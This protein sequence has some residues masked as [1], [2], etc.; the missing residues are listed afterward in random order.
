MRHSSKYFGQGKGFYA[1]TLLANHVPINV[2][3]AS[4]NTHESH[5]V[6]D[7]LYNNATEVDVDA[8]ST[9]THGANRF[10]FALLALSDWE[11]KPRYANTR[12]IIESLF[13]VVKDGD[14]WTLQLREKI[15]V[16]AVH[17][18]WDYAQ[19]IVVSL[20]QKNISQ[21]DL[22]GKLSRSSPS[23]KSLKA[24]REFDRL[25]K[26]N[27]ILEYMDDEAFRRYVQVV[28]NRGEA[29]HFL[30]SSLR[31][32]GGGKGFRGKSDEEVDIWYEASR[33]LCN[34]IIYFNS[35]I[36]EKLLERYEREG[37]RDLVESLR[38]ISPVAWVHIVLGGR[39]QFN[40]LQDTPDIHEFVASLLAAAR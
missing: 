22:V 33:L 7:L 23:D 13:D 4:L 26:A 12:G 28:L 1:D 6:F 34:C 27:Y 3:M 40:Q 19:R 15:D 20:H 39:Y 32:A 17:D 21:S 38:H 16:D 10:N 24:L 29:Y 14:D 35:L 31:K 8:I 5:N 37:K 2:K 36:L 9:D 30:Q 11:F 25:L 18:G